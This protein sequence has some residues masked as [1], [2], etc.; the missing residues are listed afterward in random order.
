VRRR[1]DGVV[2]EADGRGEAGDRGTAGGR[3]GEE[4]GGGQAGRLK[5]LPTGG[6]HLWREGEREERAG[7]WWAVCGPKAS[8]GPQKE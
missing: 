5:T 4:R 7:H 6:S 8:V 3:R 1:L 2:E